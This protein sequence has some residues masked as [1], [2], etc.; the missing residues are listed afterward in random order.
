MNKL[1]AIVA[2]SL[3]ML[4]PC[5]AQ[6]LQFTRADGH[7]VWV[8]SKEVVT[9]T[10]VDGLGADSGPTDHGTR[11]VFIAQIRLDVRE[12]LKTVVH[13]LKEADGEIK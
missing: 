1:F 2:L 11:M 9:V 8:N 6:W 3:F 10:C 12:D 4:G 5:Q 7:V 13:M